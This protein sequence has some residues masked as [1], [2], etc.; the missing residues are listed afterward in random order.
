MTAKLNVATG[1]Y[2]AP[3]NGQTFEV[4]EIL[5]NLGVCLLIDGT[6]TD[7]SFNE[8]KDLVREYEGRNSYENLTEGELL[9]QIVRLEKASLANGHALVKQAL[10][11]AITEM[12]NRKFSNYTNFQRFVRSNRFSLIKRDSCPLIK[13]I[14][15]AKASSF[16]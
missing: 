4:V 10:V 8:I 1:S 12:H 14:S 9:N 16:G 3:L 13:R 7:F 15:D 2:Y 11:E 6:K 5:G